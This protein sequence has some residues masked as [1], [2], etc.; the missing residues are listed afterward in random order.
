MRVVITTQVMEPETHTT[1]V[2]VRQLAE[3]LALRGHEVVV[4][5]GYPNHPRGSL[6]GFARME[7]GILS[8]QGDGYRTLRA[9]HHL[10]PSAKTFHRA[11]AWAA[12]ALAGGRSA[13]H[14]GP[15]DVVINFGPP[16]AGPLVSAMVARVRRARL[17]TVV[18][19]LYPDAAVSSGHLRSR[20]LVAVVAWLVRLGMSFSDEVIVLSHGFRDRLI[21]KGV[22]ARRLHVIPVWLDPDEIRPLEHDNQWRRE[23]GIPST[24]RVVLYAGTLGEVSGAGVLVEA[25]DLLRDI[26]DV[27]FLLVGEG[28]ILTG[29]MK[30]AAELELS[31]VRFVGFQPRERLAQVQATADISV[32]TMLPGAAA[33]SVPSKVVAYLAA[34]RPVVAAVDGDSDTAVCV[35]DAGGV[36]VPPGDS[37]SLALAIESLLSNPSRRRESGITARRVFDSTFSSEAALAA[38]E[39]AS[40]S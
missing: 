4:A 9:K 13:L 34:G 3:H 17:V 1:A 21:E 31:N 19:D 12:L 20:S 14:A 28:R 35:R 10:T 30:R 38:F 36:V 26:P 27:E 15:T 16:V 2:L 8:I 33:A 5:G 7:P 6:F 39:L 29:L 25:A 24:T 18:Y 32:V 37:R 40:L 11:R 22:P 23:C